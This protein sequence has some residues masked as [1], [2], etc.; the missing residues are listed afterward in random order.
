MRAPEGC[1]AISLWGSYT[2]WVP[3]IASSGQ[4]ASLVAMAV[5][6]RPLFQES[7]LR[8]LSPSRHCE[9]STGA[10]AIS[11]CVTLFP[12]VRLPSTG[13]CH[14]ASLLAMTWGKDTPWVRKWHHSPKIRAPRNDTPSRHCEASTEAEAISLLGFPIAS[15]EKDASARNDKEGIN[16]RL[17]RYS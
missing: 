14:V 12:F 9:A 13:D 10:E 15:G 8:V 4:K 3:E 17:I 11:F 2:R 5:G 1:V 16:R 6:G 7:S